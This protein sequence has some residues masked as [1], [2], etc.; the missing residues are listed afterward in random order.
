MLVNLIVPLLI[1]TAGALYTAHHIKR[2]R[3]IEKKTQYTSALHI[4]YILAA[5]LMWAFPL[6]YSLAALNDRMS[7]SIPTLRWLLGGLALILVLISG[8]LYLLDK[9]A[10]RP[11]K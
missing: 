5:A 8:C 1:L 6:L 10:Q 9:R 4:T 11:S 3:T 2:F 7:P